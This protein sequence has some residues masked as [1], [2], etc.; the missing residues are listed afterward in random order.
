[1]QNRYVRKTMEFIAREQRCKIKEIGLKQ[2]SLKFIGNMKHSWRASAETVE[3]VTFG[4]HATSPANRWST[5]ADSGGYP[6]SLEILYFFENIWFFI[7]FA[8]GGRITCTTTI[9]ISI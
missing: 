4:E 9:Y 6:N 5:K 1:M 8:V 7:G 3:N 2:E